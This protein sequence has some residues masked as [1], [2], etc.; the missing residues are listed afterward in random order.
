MNIN[1][2]LASINIAK[3]S[4]L[5]DDLKNKLKNNSSDMALREQTDKFEAIFIKTLLDSALNLDDPLY[6]KGPG[7][8]IYKSMFKA[9]LANNLSGSFGYSELLFNFL[10]DRQKLNS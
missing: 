7:D 10:K 1:N 6:E 9:E 3:D 4:N 8:E 5:V 2:T